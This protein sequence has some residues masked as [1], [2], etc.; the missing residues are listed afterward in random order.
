AVRRVRGGWEST[1]QP[2]AYDAQRYARVAATRAA[3]QRSML[4][5]IA[6]SGCRMAFLR[7]ALDDPELA[8][9]G[10][11]CG[12]CDRCGGAGAGRVPDQESVDRARTA[13]AV[14][15]VEITA[16][17][18]WPT[19]MRGLGVDHAGRIPPDEQAGAGRAVGRLD[20]LGWG[21]A[22]RELFVPIVP[23][24]PAGAVGRGAP[25]DPGVPPTL[26]DAVLAVLDAW[27]PSVAGV[28]VVRSATRPEL[29][30]HLAAGVARHLGVPV[31][32]AVVPAD[33]LP[34]GRH[35]VNSAQRLATVAQRLRLD[36]SEAAAAGLPGRSVLLV[37]DRHDS[38]WTLTVA[39]RLLR[40]AGAAEV[41]PF[42]LATG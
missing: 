37:D 32:G 3:E 2:W 5:Y 13:L 22:L 40:R 41:L 39:A 8:A 12:R 4:D 30:E 11:P 19:G 34:P 33:H 29:V 31:V 15:G 35:D 24:A 7:A 14:P 17:R 6:T 21:G 1:G 16:R 20:G 23:A 25:R 38:G 28:V 42:V 18:Q 27:H 9:D 26:R 10:A 36:L